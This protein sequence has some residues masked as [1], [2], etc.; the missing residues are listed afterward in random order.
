MVVYFPV[1]AAESEL[2]SQAAELG[3]VPW[4]GPTGGRIGWRRPS[5]DDTA[6]R[7]VLFHGNAG[8]ALHRAAFVRGFESLPGRNWDVYLYEY[9]GFGSRPGQPGEP[10]FV[11]TAIEAVDSLHAVDSDRPIYVVGESIGTGV[12]TQAAA[13]RP[14]AVPAIILITPFTNL[15]DAGRA[16]FPAFLV[17]AILRD[18]YDNERA[19]EAYN[20]RV[21]VLVAGRDDV[22][23]AELGKRLYD[24]YDGPKLL[25]VDD[26]AAHNTIDYTTASAWWE[27]MDR[28]LRGHSM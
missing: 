5:P 18:R 27:K 15:V 13:A 6:D 11:R 16:R 3:L 8:H 19:L 28:F 4:M 23:P 22:V 9:P 2:A 17:Q 12:A 25:W 21:G 14:D 26:E 24:G 1:R 7:I 20:G 10:E